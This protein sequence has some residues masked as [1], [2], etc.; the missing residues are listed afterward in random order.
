MGV[1][2]IKCPQKL[3][4]HEVKGTFMYEYVV[5]MHVVIHV[6]VERHCFKFFCE[7]PYNFSGVQLLKSIY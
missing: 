6:L 7:I 4:L 5:L 2:N 1:I 3:V